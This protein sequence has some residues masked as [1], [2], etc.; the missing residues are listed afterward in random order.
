MLSKINLILL[1]FVKMESRMAVTRS[2]GVWGTGS[3]VECEN[4]LEMDSSDG[5]TTL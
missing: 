5:C 3:C 4:V 1:K 2:S